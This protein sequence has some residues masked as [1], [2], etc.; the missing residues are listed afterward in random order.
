MHSSSYVMQARADIMYQ[1]KHL[2][3]FNQMVHHAQGPFS[4]GVWKRDGWPGAWN[5]RW[6]V[7]QM[8]G[9]GERKEFFSL[10]PCHPPKPL[11]RKACGINFMTSIVQKDPFLAEYPYLNTHFSL[12][13]SQI[14]IK[15]LVQKL[16]ELFFNAQHQASFSLSSYLAF[17]LLHLLRIESNNIF[18]NRKRHFIFQF[19]NL[20]PH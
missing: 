1:N 6:V 13:S 19:S 15:N 16:L 5:F 7:V 14:V 8:F 18:G 11:K 20:L 17:F 3:P 12:L 9:I 10:S 4:L 2:R